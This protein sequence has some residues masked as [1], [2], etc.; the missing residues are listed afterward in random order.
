[1][2]V[3]FRPVRREADNGGDAGN[4]GLD[5]HG[6]IAIGVIVPV[7]FLLGGLIYF[8]WTTERRRRTKASQEPDKTHPSMLQDFLRRQNA[9]RGSRFFGEGETDQ[10]DL[11]PTEKDHKDRHEL[12]DT[13]YHHELQDATSPIY[14][15]EKPSAVHPA[16]RD[17]AMNS[18][19][20][21]DSPRPL[22]LTS[23][24][25][26]NEARHIT[27]PSA[28]H[29]SS[30]SGD[31]TVRYSAVSP[32]SSH[33]SSWRASLQPHCFLGNF[34]NK[35]D[36]R[37]SKAASSRYSQQP[38]EGFTMMVP[39]SRRTSAISEAQSPTD[40]ISNSATDQ[41][42]NNN[43]NNNNNNNHKKRASDDSDPIS[44]SASKS[45]SMQRASVALS[46]IS[47]VDGAH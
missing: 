23:P 20:E 38:E 15:I 46:S 37:A 1:M 30:T 40:G 4:G 21:L 18:P 45:P 47:A 35:R 22:L 33:P 10:K 7:V 13:S 27:N 25:Q 3:I 9:L 41:Q 2:G 28:F 34:G 12:G 16:R 39:H 14:D 24:R 42:G 5:T 31:K 17:S 19:V 29:H 36:R 43:N 44:P 6:E 11:V 26:S 32:P 8:I